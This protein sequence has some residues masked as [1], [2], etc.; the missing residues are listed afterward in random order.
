MPFSLKF[1][2]SRGIQSWLCR[3]TTFLIAIIFGLQIDLIA[4]VGCT[5]FRKEGDRREAVVEDSLP[6]KR[7][8]I[9]AEGTRISIYLLLYLYHIRSHLWGENAFGVQE[10]STVRQANGPPLFEERYSLRR[11]FGVFVY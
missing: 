11:I 8:I 4:A 7:F 5:S 9:R 3:A 2:R 6:R 10:L 1:P